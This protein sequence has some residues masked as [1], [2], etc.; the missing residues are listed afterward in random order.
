[1]AGSVQ[2]ARAV[3][4]KTIQ[5]SLTQ[6]RVAAPGA[7]VTA[8]PLTGGVEVVKNDRGA[9]TAPAPGRAGLDIVL[10]FLRTHPDVYGLAP[11]DLGGLHYLGESKSGVTGI[12]MV[13]VEQRINGFPVFQSE[14]RF[15]LDRDGRVIRSIGLLVPN[16]AAAAPSPSPGIGADDALAAANEVG[17]DRARSLAVPARERGSRGPRIPR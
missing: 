13:R 5:T 11:A 7:E 6:L 9:L 17:R 3:R 10:D 8:T 2:Q 12:R 4:A 1:L 15:V 14:T 16:A